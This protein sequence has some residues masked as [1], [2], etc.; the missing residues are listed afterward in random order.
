MASV[1]VPESDHAAALLRLRGA[2]LARRSADVSA[3]DLAS[4]SV[5]VRRAAM[6]ALARA[7]NSS[8]RER[9][10]LGLADEDSEVL[11][12]AAL[13]LADVCTS[14]R[15]AT[16]AAL[17]ARA[18]S[19]RSRAESPDGAAALGALARA[20]GRC[21][22]DASEKLLV[23]WA[24]GRGPGDASAVL[25]LGDLATQRARLREETAVALL[26]LA[27]G[28][29]TA[30][31]WA[32]ALQP[33]GRVTHLPPS[34]VQRARDV[35]IARLADGAEG[36][37]HAVRALGRTD[38]AAVPALEGVALAVGKATPVERAAAVQALGRLGAPGQRALRSVVAKLF[39]EERDLSQA[40]ALAGAD[41]GPLLAALEALT[42][43]EGVRTALDRYAK[44]EV[45][46][47]APAPLVRRVSQ[48]RCTSARL[49]ADRDFDY[50]L[51]VH[52]D[53]TAPRDSEGA[54]RFGA[55]A[56]LASIAIEGSQL[57]GKRLRAWQRYAMGDE[58]LARIDAIRSIAWHPELDDPET[59]LAQAMT[60]KRGSLV[61]AAAEIVAKHPDRVRGKDES[62]GADASKR[63][64]ARR[65]GGREIGKALVA[66]LDDATLTADI[67]VLVALVDA[68][69]AL[70]LEGAREP[71]A[72]LCHGHH[73]L[74]RSHAEKALAQILGGEGK[75]SCAAPAAS[76]PLPPEAGRILAGAV[77]LAFE[78]DAGELRLRLD[79]SEAPV[80]VTRLRELVASGFYDGMLVH[81]VVP[82]FV[83]Q[84]GS[85]SGDGFG[86]PE[87]RPALPC[88]TSPRAFVAGAVGM[89]LAGRDTGTSQFFV[90]HGEAPHLDG[91][92]A[93]IGASE[94]PWDALVEGDR[95]VRARVVEE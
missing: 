38:E 50:P 87:G 11:G 41:F 35:A 60:S 36:R 6:R 54:G 72:R 10:F 21:A 22:S 28:S 39:P 5:E 17:S 80:A 27:A 32:M 24:A 52:C 44:L 42:E 67:E 91:Q 43:L 79:P 83:T 82:G 93:W 74:V 55:R 76:P 46:A 59:P 70:G 4:R 25:G 23:D 84:L 68:A 9:L 19:L 88:E 48:L 13:G 62:D 40:P 63:R 51:L 92:Y 16:V 26:E 3:E 73:A 65:E 86:V 78:T 7:R 64:R 29:A 85:P 89:A 2:E 34:V 56:A 57:V 33:L 47:D 14:S 30:K 71:L 49:V 94:G 95:V 58:V 69:G 8:E 53:R 12:F 20:I 75:E 31:P 18:A 66:A 15:D 37:V 61:A 45:S 90:T 1:V 81:R 77:T